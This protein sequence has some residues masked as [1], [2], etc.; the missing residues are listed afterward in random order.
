M[1]VRWTFTDPVT[2]NTYTVPINPNEGGTPPSKKT[3]KYSATAGPGG[4][5]LMFEGRDSV[6]EMQISG[7]ILDQAHLDAL[8]SWYDKRYQVSVTDD[9]GRTFSIY[10]TSFDAKRVRVASNAW[11][12]EYTMT[13]TIL[14]WV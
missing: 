9:L 1:V 3:I 2:T 7:T 13:Y 4:N 5:V 8:Q 11:K 14:S 10:I 6:Q 12:H